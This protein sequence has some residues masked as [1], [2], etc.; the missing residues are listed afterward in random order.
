MQFHTGL[1]DA[2]INLTRSSPAHLQPLIAAYPNTPVV[3]LHA[4]YP[5]T[6]EAGYLA[7]VYKNAY[8]DFGEVFPFVSKE[9]Q[10]NIVR[11]VLELCPT[12][13]ILWSSEYSNI[14]I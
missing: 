6:R 11:Q 3:L 8:L 14:G 7:S 5:F 2:D 9:G 1:G 10:R 13:K 4:S 12:N